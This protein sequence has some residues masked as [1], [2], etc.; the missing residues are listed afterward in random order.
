MTTLPINLNASLHKILVVT[1]LDNFS[2]IELRD[3]FLSTSTLSRS[4][5]DARR[6]VYRNIRRLE[7][8]K[9]LRRT[10]LPTSKKAIYKKECAFFEVT[11]K[12]TNEQK[13]DK[14]SL[15]SHPKTHDRICSLLEERLDDCQSRYLSYQNEYETYKNLTYDFP[16]LAKV[17]SV[18]QKDTAIKTRKLDGEIRAIET[19]LALSRS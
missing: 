10:Y 13:G 12:V 14:N 8:L 16:I 2:V 17:L 9:L 7:K 18:P 3:R 4:K 11:W 15:T 5:D 1:Q 6:Y 19:A